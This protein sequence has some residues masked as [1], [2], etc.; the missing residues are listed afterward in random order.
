MSP[1]YERYL[2]ALRDYLPHA[3]ETIALS[4]LPDGEAM[5]GAEILSWTTL[6]LDAREVHELGVER[7]D[8]IMA[9]RIEVAGRLGYDGP[10]DAVAA[11]NA[12]GENAAATP[13]DLV[14]LAK[15][16]VR[17]SWEAA[18]RILRHDALGEL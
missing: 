12:S 9:E 13:N 6:P 5:Y 17:R 18:P 4:A 7:F 16:Q 1:A 11:R 8:A 15:D 2:A 14:E 10:N 3:T